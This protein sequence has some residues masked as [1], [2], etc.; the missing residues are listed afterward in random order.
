MESNESPEKIEK[1]AFRTAFSAAIKASELVMQYWPSPSNTAF[2]SERVLR[3][4]SEKEGAGNYATI[5]DQESENLILDLLRR[6]P[7]LAS[8]RILA[9]ESEEVVSE[10]EWQWV[11]DPIDGTPPFK[12]GLPEFGISIG[13]LRNNEPVV[14]VIAM[15]ALGQ[16]IASRKNEG[17]HLYSFDGKILADLQD[18]KSEHVQM[19]KLLIGYDLGYMGRGSQLIE[20]VSKIADRIGYPVSYGSSSTANFRLAQGL[21]GGYFCK[22]PTKF[23]I[24][25][26]SAIIAEMGGVVSDIHGNPIDW[27]AD[28]VSY[29]AARSPEIHQSLLALIQTA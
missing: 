27:N 14:G 26:A 9:E 28:T 7:L 15:P 1:E 22:T 8:H 3:I 12:N 4:V 21:L 29:L 19:D 10:S 11:I 23:D 24:G 2:D 18:R 13:V 6:N 25:A 17:V 16:L 20:V 5:A